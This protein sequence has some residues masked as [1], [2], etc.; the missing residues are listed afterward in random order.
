MAEVV[1]NFVYCSSGDAVG[2]GISS[3][4]SEG[5][6]KS[7]TLHSCVHARRHG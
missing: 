3:Y 6:G 5:K 4:E 1:E 7:D 2:Q